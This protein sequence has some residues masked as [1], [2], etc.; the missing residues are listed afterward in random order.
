M[1]RAAKTNVTLRL[2]SE[3]LRQARVL[4]AE[5]G[6]SVSRLLSEE[7]EALL[8]RERAYDRAARRALDRLRRGFD[9]EWQPPAGREDLHE[10]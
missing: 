5:R 9:L 1:A 3:L 4:A 7:L 8:R 10:R 2:D 6:S